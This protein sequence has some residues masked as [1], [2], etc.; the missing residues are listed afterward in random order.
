[1]SRLRELRERAVLTVRDLS[2]Q[3]GVSEDAITKIENGHRKAR[4]STLRKLAKV[5]GVQPQELLPPR[6]VNV[7]GSIAAKSDARATVTVQVSRQL[8][9]HLVDIAREHEPLESAEQREV[10]E[11]LERV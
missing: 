4:P 11:V 2:Q 3:S 7:S 8:F 10:D 5:L 6:R 9:K 1:M